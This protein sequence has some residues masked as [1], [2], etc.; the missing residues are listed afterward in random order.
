MP[1]SYVHAEL[2]CALERWIEAT[3]SIHGK[4]VSLVANSLA[5][6]HSQPPNVLGSVPDV[7]LHC[8]HE[9][10][11]LIGEA[12]TPRDLETQ[13][14]KAQFLNYLEF[15]KGYDRGILLVAVPWF[16]TN[17][18]KG[19]MRVMR[20]KVHAENVQIVVIEKLPG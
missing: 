15:L 4:A 3:P 18:A 5:T 7:F 1:E 8:A 13:R 19:L 16:A 12:K 11:A 9:S 20:R 17:Q 10:F 14:S 2:I 6:K